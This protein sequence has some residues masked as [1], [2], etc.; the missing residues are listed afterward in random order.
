[1]KERSQVSISSNIFYIVL[2]YVMLCAYM[3]N[4]DFSFLTA[5]LSCT[6]LPVHFYFSTVASK[7]G[8]KLTFRANLNHK[9]HAEMMTTPMLVFPH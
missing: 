6:L 2:R 7:E 8:F 1:M 9:I 5:I 4:R 3:E